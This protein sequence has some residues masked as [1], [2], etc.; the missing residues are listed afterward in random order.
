VLDLDRS[1][2]TLDASD[3]EA[4]CAGLPEVLQA[5]VRRLKSAKERSKEGGDAHGVATADLAMRH[6]FRESRKAS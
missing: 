5:A 2:L 6:L 3:I 4:Q 1:G